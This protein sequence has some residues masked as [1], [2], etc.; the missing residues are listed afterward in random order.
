LK[1]RTSC[2]WMQRCN[3]STK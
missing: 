1:R 3:R 2:S